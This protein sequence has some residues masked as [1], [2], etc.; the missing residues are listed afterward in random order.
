MAI[1]I[2][3]LRQ[4]PLPA[5][6]PRTLLGV[7]LAAVAAFLVL[8][9][10]RPAP[11][12]PVLVAGEDLPAGTPLSE[13]EI[14][15]RQVASADGLVA[16]DDIGELG[17]WVLASPIADGEPL[18]ASQLRPSAA[19]AAPNVMAIQLDAGHAVL[20]RLS[21]GDLVDAYATTDRPGASAETTLI[22]AS[23]YVLEASHTESNAGPHRVELLLAVDDS[24][25]RTLTNAM[26]D[27]EIDLVR[28]GP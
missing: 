22:A 26:H 28:V 14:D 4:I 5:V 13:L 23:L 8:I 2:E 17:E 7:G 27:G 16:G 19:L 21:G 24:T 15:M 3:N 20:G 12:V 6:A 11:T 18:I 9:V 1:S 25:A 10:T